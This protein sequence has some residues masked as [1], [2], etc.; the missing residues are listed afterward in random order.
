M[1]GIVT[2][3]RWLVFV[4]VAL[5]STVYAQTQDN[6]SATTYMGLRGGATFT[7]HTSNDLYYPQ[8]NSWVGG[9]SLETD[10]GPNGS[11]TWAFMLNASYGT[12][13]LATANQGDCI[14][15]FGNEIQLGVSYEEYETISQAEV[16]PLLAFRVGSTGL[17]VLGGV[18]AGYITDVKTHTIMRLSD[19]AAASI[20][21]YCPDCNW[22]DDN[23]L[24]NG[25]VNFNTSS[26]VKFAL[27]GGLQYVLRI[28]STE[29]VPAV[30]Y[31]YGLSA[32]TDVN[33]TM[34]R[35]IDATISLRVP[36]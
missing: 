31:R 29:I 30:L 6:G 19:S 27:L 7:I 3:F 32:S 2:V 18:S 5:V 1:E 23:T 24:D 15:C 25:T 14:D 20:R 17:E 16:S 34:L 35:A 12:Y 10:L 9:I 13:R 36:L 21:E 8:S 11:K 28:A 22:I 26:G 4:L 33:N